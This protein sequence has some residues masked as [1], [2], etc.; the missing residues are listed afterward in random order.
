MC[1][2]LLLIAY[3][4]RVMR[5]LSAFGARQDVDIRTLA[6]SMN[7]TFNRVQFTPD[8]MPSDHRH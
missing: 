7:L 2:E 1:S 3:W 4:S 5:R 8:L 6:D